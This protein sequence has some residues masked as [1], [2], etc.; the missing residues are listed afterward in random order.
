MVTKAVA[1]QEVV[2]QEVVVNADLQLNEQRNLLVEGMEQQDEIAADQTNNKP[3]LCQEE[4]ISRQNEHERLMSERLNE[5]TRLVNQLQA[6]AQAQPQ[7]QP[8]GHEDISNN[9]NFNVSRFFGL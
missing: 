8:Q 1:E 4:I 7:A 9:N 2:G 5:L 3:N 6:Q